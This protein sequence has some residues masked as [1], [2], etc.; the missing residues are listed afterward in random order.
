MISNALNH[1]PPGLAPAMPARLISLRMMTLRGHLTMQLA[2]G[3]CLFSNQTQFF[4]LASRAQ[5][6]RKFRDFPNGPNLLLKKV[7]SRAEVVVQE[8]NKELLF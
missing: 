8:M 3:N 7:E 1:L 5:P 4:S 2:H 6:T